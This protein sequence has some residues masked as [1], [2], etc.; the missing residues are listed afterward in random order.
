MLETWLVYLNW[1]NIKW[2]IGDS[3][4]SC[5]Q[6]C[7]GK[8]CT[9]FCL[10]PTNQCWDIKYFN[11]KRPPSS[12][13]PKIRHRALVAHG[14]GEVVTWFSCHWDRPM[15]R[16]ATLHVL[17]KMYKKLLFSNYSLCIVW[18][19]K[20]LLITFLSGASTDAVCKVWCSRRKW[21]WPIWWDSTQFS[22]LVYIRFFEC[23]TIELWAKTHFPWL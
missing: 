23:A 19:I 4:V 21:A 2:R 12:H 14:E 5:P 1:K 13:G 17:S 16:Y 11:V 22:E 20:I 3:F 6:E 7:I 9:T 15:W 8:N 10:N 18:N